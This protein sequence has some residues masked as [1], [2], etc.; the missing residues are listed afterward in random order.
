MR[1]PEEAVR[2]TKACAYASAAQERSLVVTSHPWERKA[3]ATR[4]VPVKT[5]RILFGASSGRC[6]VTKARILSTRDAL[7]PMYFTP[8]VLICLTGYD[9][10]S[11]LKFS[12][13]TY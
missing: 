13:G 5:S 1:A 3:W 4:V 12:V 7:L 10:V 2:W 8:Y 11:P 6:S 9:K